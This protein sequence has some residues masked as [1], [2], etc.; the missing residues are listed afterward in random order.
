MDDKSTIKEL[1][2]L[3]LNSR[4]IYVL[5]GVLLGCYVNILHTVIFMSV[6]E[7]FI[8]MSLVI[9]SAVVLPLLAYIWDIKEV[10]PYV[11]LR[12]VLFGLNVTSAM[13]SVLFFVEVLAG[14]YVFKFLSEPLYFAVSTAPQI[15]FAVSSIIVILFSIIELL[16]HKSETR[17]AIHSIHS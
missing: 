3:M 8:V 9:F 13:F 12:V 10:R 5:A 1:L 7:F 15:S 11:K 14:N 4:R 6:H 2:T 17:Y 16:W